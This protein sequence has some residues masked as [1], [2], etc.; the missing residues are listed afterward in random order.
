MDVDLAVLFPSAIWQHSLSFS[1]A[2]PCEEWAQL[3]TGIR[4]SSGEHVL[5]REI[6]SLWCPLLPSSDVSCV[7]HILQAQNHLKS[8][9]RSSFS[10]WAVQ[11]RSPQGDFPLL[12][13]PA[14]YFAWLVEESNYFPAMA[15][16][17][18]RLL[19]R[20]TVCCIKVSGPEKSQIKALNRQD[21]FGQFISFSFLLWFFARLSLLK[22]NLI[23][24]GISHSL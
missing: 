1:P 22:W 17:N 12:K 11:T 6:F 8:Q 5:A 15:S 3:I 9:A 14:K 21:P 18:W 24:M 10:S 2:P 7:F 4:I 23:F 20:N 16:L 13:L 19:W